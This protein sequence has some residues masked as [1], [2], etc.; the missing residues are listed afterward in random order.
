MILG[1]DPG[2]PNVEV[3]ADPDLHHCHRPSV[4]FIENTPKVLRGFLLNL[5][6]MLKIWNFCKTFVLFIEYIDAK[7]CIKNKCHSEQDSGSMEAG[8]ASKHL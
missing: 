7:H 8:P 5:P 3:N 1:P 2:Q 4:L 6:H